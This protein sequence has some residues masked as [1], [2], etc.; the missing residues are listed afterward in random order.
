MDYSQYPSRSVL[1]VDMRSFYASCAA[2][3]LGLDPMTCFLAVVGNTERQGSIVLAASPALK[4]E[5]GVQT[6]TRLYQLPDDPRIKLVNPKM[7]LFVRV[8]TELTRLFCRYVP[9]DAIHTYSVDESFIQVDGVESMWGDARTIAMKIQDDMEREFGLPC[10]VGIGPNLLMAKLCLDLEAK[11]SAGG[12]AVW[13]YEDVKTKL[14]PLSPLRRM[15]GIGSRLEKTLNRMG[16]F[17]VG[18]LAHY[19]LSRLEKTFG[20]MGNQLYYH[21]WGIDLSA[22]GAPL[23]EGQVSYGKKPDSASRLS[24]SGGSQACHS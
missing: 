10:A 6:G 24:E 9:P 20:V 22:I 8:S 15:W 17:T 11:K 16:I 21:A 5:F 14:W 1:C 19:D 7:G 18:Q 3:L 23:M 2:V 12:V 4:R 13:G